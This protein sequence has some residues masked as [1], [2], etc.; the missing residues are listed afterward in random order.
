MW[1]ERWIRRWHGAEI[2]YIRRTSQG[3]RAFDSYAYRG[4]LGQIFGLSH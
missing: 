3:D 2:A 4:V 1:I